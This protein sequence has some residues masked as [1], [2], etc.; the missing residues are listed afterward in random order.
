MTSLYACDFIRL[1]MHGIRCM[2]GGISRR[3]FFKGERI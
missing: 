3:H 1:H 2:C